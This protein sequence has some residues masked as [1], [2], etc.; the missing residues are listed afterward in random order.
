MSQMP[1]KTGSGVIAKAAASGASLAL[2]LVLVELIFSDFGDAKTSPL[3]HNYFILG[4]ILLFGLAL[5]L[6]VI[7]KHRF[8]LARE[9]L[10]AS[11]E[12]FRTAFHTSPDSI[13][14]NR[15]PDSRYVEVN[16]GFCALSG[17]A[18]EEVIGHTPNELAVWV[19]HGERAKFLEGLKSKG[20]VKNLEAN[21]RLKD[22]SIIP[23]LV[24][25]K[26][27][28]LGGKPHILSVTREIGELKEAQRARAKSQEKYARIFGNIQDVYYEATVR[29]MLIDISPS[30][31][32]VLG[33]TPTE[34]VGNAIVDF[35][36]NPGDRGA[37][38]KE[39]TSKGEVY[40]Y[41]VELKDKRGG[42][43]HVS[44]N[45]R[46]VPDPHGGEARYC[47]T[48]RDVELQH[49]AQE[50]LARSE[51]KYRALVER[52]NSMILRLDGAGRIVFAN[53]YALDFLGRGP[54]ELLGRDAKELMASPQE[55][56]GANPALSEA[57]G[58][59]HAI[60]AE[61]ARPDGG[62]AFVNWSVSADRNGSGETKG[63]LCVGLDV[64]AEV[65]AE[66]KVQ[67]MEA[68]L[69]Q[70]QKFE[71]LGTLAS[72]IAHDFNN[73]LSAVVGYA[74]LT[75][76]SVPEGSPASEHQKAIL[77]AGDRAAQ[78]VRQIL[79]FARRN[80]ENRT[81]TVMLAPL[82]REVLKFLRASLPANVE[83]IQRIGANAVVEA[84]PTRIHQVLMN[85]CT[86]AVKAMPEGGALTVT[87]GRRTVPPDAQGIEAALKHGEYCLLTVADTGVGMPPDVLS[88]AFDPFFTTRVG[89]GGTGMGLAVV[90]G[91]VA[92]L[93]GDI[94]V[95]SEIGKGS[96]FMVYLPF[97]SPEA[98]AA[99]TRESEVPT[100][101]GRVLVVD[102]EPP[103]A[104]A[105]ARMLESLGYRAI[106]ATG[107][108]EALASFE[109]GPE[110]FD[111]AIVDM[112]MPGMTGDRLI[113]KLR[114]LRPGLPAIL[115]SGFS[116]R[117]NEEKA[118]ALNLSAY[119][120]KPLTRGE[121]ARAAKKA[122]KGTGG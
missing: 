1:S 11:E 42:G 115:C 70:A 43:K 8:G 106:V 34:A 105:T 35:Y 66:R 95:E 83:I 108:G 44:V 29:G 102:D 12:R 122:L 46:L 22:G 104:D 52:S 5:T 26:M 49:R 107:A 117:M 39:L 53:E 71:A 111:L 97:A 79:T 103:I 84:D 100:G 33:Y 7:Y 64:T 20:E 99:E 13:S 72:G 89:E 78:L 38:I 116:E 37:F 4:V 21:F 68:H 112:T 14:I 10:A 96:T 80:E 93:K 63:Y 90:R 67:L 75:L 54:G 3:L 114:A 62:R 98:I 59:G 25:A 27:I 82:T 91:I 28:T 2:A 65:E 30:V 40:D 41:L 56:G 45:A 24:S 50:A 85:L 17:F 120:T 19:D 55:K 94:L 118:A 110:T 76:L 36:V 6:F 101:S 15:L 16:D 9:N 47:G 32:K 61:V 48:I 69:A 113:A 88:R 73:V 60:L 77:A 92:D 87:L 119:L 18:R 109:G 86:N 121:L 81:V 57:A 58:M 23:G 74:E 51:G 31:E